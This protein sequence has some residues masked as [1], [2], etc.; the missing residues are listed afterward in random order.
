MFYTLISILTV[1]SGCCLAVLQN[2][3]ESI[4]CIY[5]EDN[6]T[7][8]CNWINGR[9][10]DPEANFT[11][12][13]EGCHSGIKIICKSRNGA[14]SFTK[15]PL[16]PFLVRVKVGN[17]SA[18]EE[19]NCTKINPWNNFKP[20]PPLIT[21]L[22]AVPGQKQMLR[23][24]WQKTP[25]RIHAKCEIQYSCVTKNHSQTV[26]TI[27]GEEETSFNI[28]NLWDFANYTVVIRCIPNN[29]IFWSDWSH[30]A[31]QRTE[32]QAPLKVDLW[33]VIESN[34]ST[35][36]RIVHLLWKDDKEFPS[37]GIIDEY[38]VKYCTKNNTC[39]KEEKLHEKKFTLNLTGE[40]CEISVVACNKKG[41]SPAAVLRIP[42]V[43]EESADHQRIFRLNVSALKEQLSVTWETTDLEID[44]YIVEWYNRM[45]RSWQKIG[46]VTKWTSP[47]EA[48]SSSRY[49][50]I[51]VYPLHKGEIKSP[52]CIEIDMYEFL[53]GLSAKAENISKNEATIKWEKIEERKINNSSVNY[54]IFYKA[55]NGKELGLPM[56]AGALEYRLKS[57]Q[58]NTKYTVW[59]MASTANGN[60]NGTATTFVT[61]IF[62]EID[63]ILIGVAAGMFILCLLTIGMLWGLKRQ[64][65][66]RICWPRIP[67]PVITDPVEHN[68]P[69]AADLNNFISDTDTLISL[70]DTNVHSKEHDGLQLPN[71]KNIL[72]Q[73]NDPAK[74]LVGSHEILISGEDKAMQT[75]LPAFSLEHDIWNQALQS[76]KMDFKDFENE[77]A[78]D[79][80]NLNGKTSVNPYLKN[81]VHTRE[82]LVSE[83]SG[84]STKGTNTQPGAL[85]SCLPNGAEQS[86]VTLDTFKLFPN[87]NAFQCA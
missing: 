53:P 9:N 64:T 17:Q 51:S 50:N 58:P 32:E 84:R 74:D 40:A 30:E 19:L 49:Y 5:Y 44:G 61:K 41:D 16:A 82:F 72:K 29:S 86:Y 56:S 47:K 6:K 23:V 73:A 63:V 75:F 22:E 85:A 78:Q 36:T 77:E 54:T 68:L 12:T 59:V 15:P 87:T 46:N 65:I 8:I 4:S 76:L 21:R 20:K 57:L 71:Q 25:K 55:E 34:H 33:R 26:E 69:L 42:S 39:K 83:N 60:K 48:F 62:S 35:G 31:T 52:T 3:H 11:L 14:C 7:L 45:E 80:S 81:S 10:I 70:L 1:F 24:S 27:A 18:V 28:T 43:Q 66:K 13:T 2:I 38:V 37:S 67:Y 79:Q